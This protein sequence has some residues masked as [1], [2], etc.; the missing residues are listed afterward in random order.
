MKVR[1]LFFA[2]CRDITGTRELEVEVVEG[3]CVGDLRQSL[4]VRYPGLKGIGPSLSA[5][6]NTDYSGDSAV[7]SDGDEVAFLPPVSGG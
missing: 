4:V 7:L 6:V 2:S 1:V 5:A 3:A